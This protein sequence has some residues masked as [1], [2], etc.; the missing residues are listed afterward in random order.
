MRVARAE[1][2]ASSTGAPSCSSGA[3]AGRVREPEVAD[4]RAPVSAEEDVVGLEVAVDD[5]ARVRRRETLAGLSKISRIAS[6][7]RFSAWSHS[8]QRAAL[9]ELHREEDFAVVR[10]DVVDRHH[11]RVRELRDR[12]RLAEESNAERRRIA[13]ARDASARSSLSATRRSSSGSYA[14]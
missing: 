14:A 3:L 13:R 12:A 8:A 2:G 7:G 10:A 5:P 9:D 4:A 1:S 6:A 11:V